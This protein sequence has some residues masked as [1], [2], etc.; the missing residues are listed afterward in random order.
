ME[1]FNIQTIIILETI[2]FL[3]TVSM[4]IIRGNSTLVGAYLLQS[5]A[6]VGLL[7]I[8]AYEATS[9]TYLFI[10]IIVFFVKV[11]IAPRFFLRLI[12]QSR[13]NLS[14][15]YLSVPMTL[16]VIVGLIFLSQSDVFSPLDTLINQASS[17]K[18]M[19]ISTLFISL[20]LTINRKGAISQIIGVLSF[21]NAA[22]ALGF[23]VGLQQPLSLE[24]GVLFDIFI[25]LI[26]SIA[27]VSMIQKQFESHDVTAMKHLKEE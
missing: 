18:M 3:V 5:L 10:A 7:G 19:L 6:I 16:G 22:V 9:L 14:S 12:N 23:F 1:I 15:S 13:I 27:F 17:L 11:I 2:I 21:E 24:L 20:F 8:H 26:I 25:W 4:H